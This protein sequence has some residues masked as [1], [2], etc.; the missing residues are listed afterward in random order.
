[1]NPSTSFNIESLNK[2]ELVEASRVLSITP[3][4]VL[5]G[6]PV[7]LVLQFGAA[8]ETIPMVKG[9]GQFTEEHQRDESG[10]YFIQN[11]AF[12][13]AKNRKETDAW[14]GEH[15]HKDFVVK[16]TDRNQNIRIVGTPDSP[17]RL[18][19]PMTNPASGRN[20]YAF[21]LYAQADDRAPYLQDGEAVTNS[22]RSFS[23]DFSTDFSL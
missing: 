23:N 3:G 18:T 1:M 11:I 8:F 5:T 4:D 12:S 17:A 20:E 9:T 19:A 13:H 15:Q 6:A 10:D 7:R 21:T 22:G 2:I 16:V 14:L